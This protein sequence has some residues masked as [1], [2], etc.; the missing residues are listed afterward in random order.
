MVESY[1]NVG[2]KSISRNGAKVTPGRKGGI[3]IQDTSL[4]HMVV[5][6]YTS[7]SPEG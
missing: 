2:G 5:M 3:A 7:I 6:V 1:E 4:C